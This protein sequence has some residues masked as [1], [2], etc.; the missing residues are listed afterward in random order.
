M[1][2]AFLTTRITSLLVGAIL[3]TV[4]TVLGALFWMANE[5][6]KQAA[7][8]SQ[9]MIAGGVAALQETLE[10]VTKDYSWWQ[11]AYDNVRA[12]D[13]EWIYS[14]M[15]SGAVETETVDIIVIVQPDQSIRFA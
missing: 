5:H 13:G 4:V 6:N 12:E 3:I 7:A 8:N 2:K 9:T 1:S 11:D 10:T 15:G 14:N